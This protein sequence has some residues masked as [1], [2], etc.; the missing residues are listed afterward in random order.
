MSASSRYV[1]RYL[2]RADRQNKLGISVQF[3]AD[4]GFGSVMSTGRI[5]H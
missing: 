2:A 5:L 4:M 1:E 3:G